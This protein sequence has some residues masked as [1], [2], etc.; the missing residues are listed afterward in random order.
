MAEGLDANEQAF[1]ERI[2]NSFRRWLTSDEK[3]N[4]PFRFM[5]ALEEALIEARTHDDPAF[6]K[7]PKASR[8]RLALTGA[9]GRYHVTPRGLTSDMLSKIVCIDGIV[10]RASTVTPK[11]VCSV[12]YCDQAEGPNVIVRTIADK[13]GYI[14]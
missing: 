12:F 13:F 5:P 7:D 10:T 8:P 6:Q 2:K 3:G 4:E 1:R 11:L 9:F 14:T